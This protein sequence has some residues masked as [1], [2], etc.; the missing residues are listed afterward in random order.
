MRIALVN[1][2]SGLN[3]GDGATLLAI[4]EFLRA[5]FPNALISCH[6]VYRKEDVYHRREVFPDGE[7]YRLFPALLPYMRLIPNQYGL[8][9]WEFLYYLLRGVVLIAFSYLF[10]KKI[11]FMLRNLLEREALRDLTEADLVICIGGFFFGDIWG[12]LK[13]FIHSFTKLYP[14]LIAKS[15][16]RRMLI[17]NVSMGPFQG[18]LTRWLLKQVLKGVSQ[19]FVREPK[20]YEHLLNAGVGSEKIEVIPDLVF[21]LREA[22]GELKISAMNDNVA[23]IAITLRTPLETQERKKYLLIIANL[24]DYL[25]ETKNAYIFIIPHTKSTP[26]QSDEELELQK[27]YNLVRR[28]D[29][30]ILIPFNP[31]PNLVKSLYKTMDLVISS[32]LHGIILSRP[33]PVVAIPITWKYRYRGIMEQLGL[34]D[35][36]VDSLDFEKIKDKIDECWVRRIQIRAKQQKVTRDLLEEFQLLR[37]KL[38]SY[39]EEEK[40]LESME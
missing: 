4:L 25:I 1:V 39:I 26:D 13:G 12:G 11:I 19:V 36:C 8:S 23:K 6:T 16:R 18:R 15:F 21:S 28:K 27:L 5:T 32:R 31:S 38:R 7:N 14:L 10:H 29:R 3:I 30:V 37:R 40:S 34:S 20:S 22:A 9:R 24:I 35:Y 17:L 2:W 33:T